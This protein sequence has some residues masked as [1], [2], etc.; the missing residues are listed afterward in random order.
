MNQATL[1]TGRLGLR[2]PTYRS[3]SDSPL[4]GAGF[5]P[6]VPGESGFDFAREVRGRTESKKAIRRASVARPVTSH[7]TG[8]ARRTRAKVTCRVRRL[9]APIVDYAVDHHCPPLH[10]RLPAIRE[11][12]VKDDRPRTILR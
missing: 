11:A 5:E 3:S 12:V 10:L 9:P 1:K 8:T 4:E 6:A 2:S 7:T